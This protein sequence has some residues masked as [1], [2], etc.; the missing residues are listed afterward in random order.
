[1]PSL[2]ATRRLSVESTAFVRDSSHSRSGL[3]KSVV[4]FVCERLLAGRGGDRQRLHGAGI[5]HIVENNATHIGYYAFVFQRNSDVIQVE[6]GTS[7]TSGL[8]TGDRINLGILTPAQRFSLIGG[9]PSESH[10]VV[11]VTRDSR[12]FPVQ[13]TAGA[14][15]RSPRAVLTR[16]VG[17]PL[18]FFLS[19]ALASALFL[20]RPRPITLAFYVYTML[21]LI[22]VNKTALDLATWPINFDVD[23][24]MQVVY[25]LAQVMILIFAQRLYGRP[26]RAWPWFFGAAIFLSLIDFVVWLDPIV[27]TVFQRYGFPG[28]AYLFMSLTDSLLLIVVLGGL[29]YIAS[30][31]TLIDRARV[32]WVIAGIALAPI[33]D[34]TWALT[35]FSLSNL[36]SATPRSRC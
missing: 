18:A 30:G 8:Q 9:A 21:M 13:L 36:R 14:I 35:N 16:D 17:V 27:W 5:R 20:V 24:F 34:L 31:A 33:L 23:L 4:S 3:V 11:Q 25:P 22:K 26:S 32:T 1:M 12:T 19:L 6:P 15:D 7:M 2:V 29:A 28:P 10:L